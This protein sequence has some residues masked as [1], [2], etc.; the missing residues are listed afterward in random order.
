MSLNTIVDCFAPATVLEDAY[1]LCYISY[2]ESKSALDCYRDRE[3]E[4]PNWESSENADYSS[5]DDDNVDE[6]AEDNDVSF[7]G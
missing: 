1:F 5:S 2:I 6:V 4:E 7:D 3:D